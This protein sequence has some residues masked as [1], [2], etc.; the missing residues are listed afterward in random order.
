MLGKDAGEPVRI[1]VFN[2]HAD[3]R[4]NDRWI[5]TSRPDCHELWTAADPHQDRRALARLYRHSE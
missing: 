2:R 4:R 5:G 1:E 3:H